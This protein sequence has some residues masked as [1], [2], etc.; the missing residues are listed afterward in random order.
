MHRK[1]CL[2]LSFSIPHS[3][4]T[5]HLY[6]LGKGGV[7]STESNKNSILF[8]S[9]GFAYFYYISYPWLMNVGSWRTESVIALQFYS[10]MIFFSIMMPS[11]FQKHF[12]FIF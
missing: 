8:Q 5:P 9:L 1:I 11:I 6:S 10:H 3:I 4:P 2:A 7:D 12:T